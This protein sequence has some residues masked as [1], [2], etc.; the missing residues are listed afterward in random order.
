MGW[1]WVKVW[2]SGDFLMIDYYIFVINLNMMV[3]MMEKIGVVVWMV[4][5]LLIRIIV[6][7]LFEGLV[8]I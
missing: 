8:V 7:N 5:L 4:F 3:L 2:F 1:M 6:V